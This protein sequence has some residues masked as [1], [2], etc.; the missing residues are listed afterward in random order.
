MPKKRIGVIER[1][2]GH[3]TILNAVHLQETILFLAVTNVEIKLN[4]DFDA[5]SKSVYLPC[6]VH[7]ATNLLFRTYL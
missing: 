5:L 6:S 4:Q 3:S 7:A 2:L 1:T